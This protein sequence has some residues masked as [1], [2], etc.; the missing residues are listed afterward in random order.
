MGGGV[1][2]HR[3]AAEENVVADGREEIHALLDTV[4]QGREENTIREQ[5]LH[6]PE[7][8]SAGTDANRIERG[9][10]LAE[11]FTMEGSSTRVM[12]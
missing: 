4:L 8:C 10:S 1:S 3:R 5:T 11:V 12:S 6:H 7:G 9:L 2:H